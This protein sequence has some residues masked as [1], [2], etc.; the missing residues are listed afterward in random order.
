[1]KKAAPFIPFI[2][3]LLLALVFWNVVLDTSDFGVKI[4]GHEAQGP[5]EWLFGV[6]LAGG[7]LIIA[8]V[9]TVVVAA[10]VALLCAGIGAVT[11]TALIVGVVIAVLAVSPLMLPLLIP[12]GIVWYVV[13]RNQQAERH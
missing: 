7:A 9:M 11:I 13:S 1:M 2:I 3:L 4:N 8:I 10:L 6:V 12:I 5:L